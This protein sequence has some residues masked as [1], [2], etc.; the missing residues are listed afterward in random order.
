MPKLSTFWPTFKTMFQMQVNGYLLPDTMYHLDKGIQATNQ[1]RYS[2][3]KVVIFNEI[4][5]GDGFLTEEIMW[6][7]PAEETGS[8]T[9]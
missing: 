7:N 8:Y 4:I 2:K 3:K 1:L 6:D 5:E 9:V